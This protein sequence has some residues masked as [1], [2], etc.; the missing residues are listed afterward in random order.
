MIINDLEKLLKVSM[1]F[2]ENYEIFLDGVKIDAPI[3][4][5]ELSVGD[6]SVLIGAGLD[7]WLSYK[8]RL[9][10]SGFDDIDEIKVFSDEDLFETKMYPDIFET[11]NS[12]LFNNKKDF[13]KNIREIEF[14]M[15]EVA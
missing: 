4:N 7:F 11:L 5:T 14:M 13:S 8:D 2:Y 10:A 3:G 9:V 6:W 12:V 1:E 15:N